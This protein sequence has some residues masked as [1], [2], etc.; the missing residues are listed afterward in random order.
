MTEKATRRARGPAPSPLPAGVPE[1]RGGKAPRRR[2][3]LWGAGPQPQQGTDPLDPQQPPFPSSGETEAQKQAE[4]GTAPCPL[5]PCDGTG[6]AQL[7][8][9]RAGGDQCGARGS[10]LRVPWAGSH[11]LPSFGGSMAWG[12]RGL[13]VTKAA[14]RQLGVSPREPVLEAGVRGPGTAGGLRVPWPGGMGRWER[15][16]WDCVQASHGQEP[17]LGRIHMSGWDEAW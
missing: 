6:P 16:L 7:G 2:P 1:P 17:A 14:R 5:V 10:V 12:R 4:L 8:V 3:E 9:P 15:W 13:C 11:W